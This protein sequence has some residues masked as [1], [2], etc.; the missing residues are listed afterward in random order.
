MGITEMIEN[1]K[2]RLCKQA[3]VGQVL[4]DETARTEIESKREVGCW[5]DDVFRLSNVERSDY[6]MKVEVGARRL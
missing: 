6:E 4:Y 1:T 3:V 5:M 2:D